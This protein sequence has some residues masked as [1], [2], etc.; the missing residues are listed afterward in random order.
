MERNF[1]PPRHPP[2]EYEGYGLHNRY[3]LKSEPMNKIFFIFNWIKIHFDNVFMQ[4]R[5]FDYLFTSLKKL[6]VFE[7]L[8]RL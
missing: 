1:R 8:K 2:L 5:G 6:F 4:Q 7:L 3:F